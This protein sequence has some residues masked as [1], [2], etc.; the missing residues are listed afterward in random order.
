[1]IYPF[2][3]LLFSLPITFLLLPILPTLPPLLG[4][5]T[6]A[7]SPSHRPT[8]PMFPTLVPQPPSSP[9]TPLSNF[10]LIPTST[11]IPST[12]NLPP[13][14][15]LAFESKT[16]YKTNGK[17]SYENM[18]CEKIAFIFN[19]CW[20]FFYFFLSFIIFF[21]KKKKIALPMKSWSIQLPKFNP[22][23]TNFFSFFLYTT[24]NILSSSEKTKKIKIV[25][26]GQGCGGNSGKQWQPGGFGGG[27][28]GA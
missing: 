4:P 17:A 6:A 28:G 24:M 20:L 22:S 8:H 15:R 2:Y 26:G 25:E 5:N 19:G 27:V 9:S 1:M 21:T 12:P 11:M 13:I 18:G 10:P 7:A 23:Q 3:P 14:R 16:T